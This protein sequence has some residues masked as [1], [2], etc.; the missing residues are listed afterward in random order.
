MKM[1]FESSEERLD[2]E[3]ISFCINLAANKRNAQIICE[4]SLPPT[5][6]HAPVGGALAP[7]PT[8]PCSAFQI[9]P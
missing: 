3:L 8:M 2:A 9:T 6:I 5:H 7:L 4:G 1:L